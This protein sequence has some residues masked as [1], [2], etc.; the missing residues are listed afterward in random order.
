MILVESVEIVD[1]VVSHVSNVAELSICKSIELTACFKGNHAIQ[2]LL[3]TP[4]GLN[5]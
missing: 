1:E 4:V 2:T 3:Q 5:L